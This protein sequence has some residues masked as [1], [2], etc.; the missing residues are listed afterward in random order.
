MQGSSSF[1]ADLCLVW[2][3]GR[4]FG[5]ASSVG[6]GLHLGAD[7]REVSCIVEE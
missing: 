6:D 7:V 2:F 1:L 5:C 3:G 4:G